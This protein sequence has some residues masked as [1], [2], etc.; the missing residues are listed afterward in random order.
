MDLKAEFMMQ[1]QRRYES[2][3]RNYGGDNSR[4]LVDEEVTIQD[5]QP[6]VDRFTKDKAA[7]KQKVVETMETPKD[8]NP[9][10]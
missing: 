2:P 5:S 1:D 8:N 4:T 6:R 10:A 9:Y 7:E 3:R